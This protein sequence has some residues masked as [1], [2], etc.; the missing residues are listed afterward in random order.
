MKKISCLGPAGT[1][2]EI[3][4]SEYL[5]ATGQSRELIFGGTFQEVLDHLAFGRAQ[6][7]IVP[8]E[9]LIEGAINEVLDELAHRE[10]LTILAEVIVPI[11]QNL[12]GLS[13]A[14]MSEITDVS[15]MPQPIAQCRKFLRTMLPKAEV[16]FTSS[17]VSA[18]EQIIKEN[19]VHHAAIGPV[20]KVE[21]LGLVV[22]QTN[23]SDHAQNCTR[24]LVIQK[25][26]SSLEGEKVSIVFATDKDVP[27]GLFRILKEF[28]DR[29]INL[30]RIESRP[31]KDFLGNYLFFIDFQAALSQVHV[32]EA[33][34][35][36]EKQTT[37]FKILGGYKEIK[38]C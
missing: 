2:S 17:T 18:F 25:G 37:W 33:M 29:N 5:K 7:A 38:L 36:I 16:H 12:I 28:A 27:G 11:K 34:A 35:N 14:K 13:G 23:I 1:F 20:N 19:N 9:N 4:A 24:F 30:T 10:E 15:S 21:D 22:L 6:Q 26:K 31:T 8:V 32:K 3:A